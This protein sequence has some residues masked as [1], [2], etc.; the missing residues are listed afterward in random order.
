MPR[1]KIR[2]TKSKA[3]KPITSRLTKGPRSAK[4]PKRS[5]KLPFFTVGHSTRTVAEFVELLRAAEVEVVVDIRRIPRSRTNPQYNQDILGA[6]LKPYGIRYKYV[7]ELGGRRPKTK[8]LGDEVNGLWRNR[9]FHNYADYAL[10]EEFAEGLAELI[11]LGRSKRC[12]IMCSEAVWWRCHRR[13]VADYL[14]AHGEKVFHLMSRDRIEPAH[15][16]PGARLRRTRKIEYP[17]TTG[18]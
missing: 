5:A 11:E 18:A 15:L 1:K 4:R 16:T 12:A 14:L 13:I 6:K 17:A 9:S 10:S 3:T 2:S 7:A 8:G